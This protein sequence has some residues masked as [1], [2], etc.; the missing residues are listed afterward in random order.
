MSFAE[1]ALEDGPGRGQASGVDRQEAPYG[2][3][4]DRYELAMAWSYWEDG[5]AEEPA[6]FDTFFRKLPFGGGFAVAAGLPVLLEAL[7]DFRF[8]EDQLAFL[9]QDGFGPGFLD[10]LRT[11]RFRAE[12][13]A[14]PEGEIVFPLEPLLRVSGGLLE[15]QLVET[16]VLNT[17]NFQSLVATKAARCREAAGDRGLSEFGLRRAQG[18]GGHAASRAA[19]VGGFDSTSNMAA[20]HAY[21]LRAAG[22]MAHSFVQS[23]DSE[24]E[25]FRRFAALHGGSTVLL[26]DT[27]DTLRSG[28]P[29]ALQVAAE[30]REA[31]AGILGVR[32]DSGDLAYFAKEVRKGLD[33]AG[34]PELKIVASNQLDEQ[35]IQSLLLQDAPID[36]FGVGTAVAVGRPDAALDGV[37]K[38]AEID[39][40][41]CLKLSENIEKIT[42]PGR[43]QVSRYRD[44]DGR[45]LADAIHL[46]E[47]DPPARM[48]HPHE[49]G[50]SRELDPST[51][52]P[53]LRPYGRPGQ[54]ERPE[55]GVHEAAARVR[56]RLAD[57]PPEHCR[58][59]N[60]HVYKVG[61]SPAL[62][63]LREELATR[64]RS[65]LPAA[66][67]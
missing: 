25:A 2:L 47:E 12:V 11:F 54:G 48:L 23:C 46:A 58:F 38:L 66:A 1:R 32:L 22:T 6:V 36:L 3:H 24:L 60:P 50:K 31:G 64:E 45:F 37:Y 19:C 34:F 10:Y 52:E 28:L 13:E 51:A 41:P 35:V 61:L 16:L 62:L 7:A 39:G 8:S 53:L 5:R 59:E 21:G 42:L 27:Y 67:P 20:A 56:A 63:A 18:A 43:K 29:N 15:C 55:A 9:E 44:G 65:D 33:E 26:L 17:L 57:L 4:A 49:A 40:R 30:Q 14:V